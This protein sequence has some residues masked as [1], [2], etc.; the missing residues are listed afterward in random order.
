MPCAFLQVNVVR[1]VFGLLT[2]LLNLWLQLFILYNVNHYIVLLGIQSFF[3]HK[4]QTFCII[5]LVEAVDLWRLKACLYPHAACVYPIGSLE[6]FSWISGLP[7][8]R[9]WSDVH[10]RNP[11]AFV[12]PKVLTVFFQVTMCLILPQFVGHFAP[13]SELRQNAVHDAQ[14][15]YARFHHEVFDKALKVELPCLMTQQFCTDVLVQAEV[16]KNR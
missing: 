7:S 1:F 10:G 13:S 14:V 12:R 3:L 5:L 11:Y 6:V 4:D 8:W 16:T 15:N 9:H 2:L